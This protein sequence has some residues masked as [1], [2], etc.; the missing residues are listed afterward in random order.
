MNIFNQTHSH[1]NNLPFREVARGLGKCF[2]AL[3]AFCSLFLVSCKE[4]DDSVEEFANW[5]ETNEAYV[6]NL[7][8]RAVKTGEP[9]K[10]SLT[11]IKKWS[12]NGENS[13]LH[14]GAGDY[15]YVEVLNEGD[16]TISP[17]YTDTVRVHY[18]GRLLP[19]ASYANGYVF[20]QSWVGEYDTNTN[21]P[22]K[23]ALYAK[24]DGI[25]TALQRMHKGDRWKIYVPYELGYVSSSSE[26]ISLPNYSVQ[27]FDITL[28]NFWHVG[29]TVP[30]FH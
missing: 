25:A 22:E 4:S 24:G 18:Q 20:K 14:N 17:I 7:Y 1:S 27:V 13:D 21:V 10:G 2:L 26:A 12:Y 29:E 23:F 28:N 19:S 9:V 15:I 11:A 6:N 16:G 30:G 3:L 8:S 5:Q